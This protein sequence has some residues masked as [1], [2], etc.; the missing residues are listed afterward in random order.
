MSTITSM[1]VVVL[2]HWLSV[3]PDLALLVDDLP[4]AAPA[5]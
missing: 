2:L 1:I 3:M 5:A 4:A